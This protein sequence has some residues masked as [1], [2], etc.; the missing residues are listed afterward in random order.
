MGV[1]GCH[2]D[3]RR[4]NAYK[5]QVVEMHGITVPRT[6]TN[7][8]IIYSKC[9]VILV[10]FCLMIISPGEKKLD[11]SPTAVF[12]LKSCATVDTQSLAI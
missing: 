6:E 1:T 3:H 10:T 8:I 11:A 2:T 4:E 7:T 12:S 9:M 5:A